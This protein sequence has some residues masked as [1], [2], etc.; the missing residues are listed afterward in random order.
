MYY[1]VS[2]L[3]KQEHFYSLILPVN[4]VLRVTRALHEVK[5]NP[6]LLYDGV[7]ALFLS[8][9]KT[10]FIRLFSSEIKS[11]FPESK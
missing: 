11:V 1:P 2:L 8:I 7:D 5:L 4:K 10:Y 3:W 9:H 6:F